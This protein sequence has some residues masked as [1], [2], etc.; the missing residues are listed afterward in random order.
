MLI[1]IIEGLREKLLAMRRAGI[2][3]NGVNMDPVTVGA[4]LAAIAGGAGGALGSQLW[5]GLCALVRRPFMHGPAAESGETQ[6]SALE[7]E[8]SDRARAVALAE[9]LLTRA[10]RDSDFEKALSDWWSQ[11]GQIQVVSTEVRN[12]VR[13]GTFYGPVVQSGNVSGL[14]FGSAAKPT[15]RRDA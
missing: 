2:Q 14:A 12:V 10:E 3:L 5:A 1:L 7:K 9:A 13:G 15:P 8:P 11:A 4:V 6:L